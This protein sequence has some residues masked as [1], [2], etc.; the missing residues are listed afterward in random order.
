MFRNL[1]FVYGLIFLV[2]CNGQKTANADEENE[3]K[4]VSSEKIKVFLREKNFEIVATADLVVDYDIQKSLIAGTTDEYSNKV[5]F[6]DTL[7]SEKAK[8]LLL[9]LKDDSSYDWSAEKVQTDFSPTRQ[10]LVKNNS[11]R[12]FILVDEKAMKL[13]F[14]NL[15]GQKVVKLS[16][17]LSAYFSS[18]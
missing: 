17:K 8:T 2:S 14:I 4:E 16:S 10:F 13:G 6:N 9:L 11:E 5:V 12:I 18:L 1:I 7:K 3:N 15:D